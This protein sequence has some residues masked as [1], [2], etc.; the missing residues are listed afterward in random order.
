LSVTYQTLVYD[1]LVAGGT[2]GIAGGVARQNEQQVDPNTNQIIEV[3]RNITGYR[4][5][6]MLFAHYELDLLKKGRRRY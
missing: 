3:T 2:A 5:S 6:L 4:A 1:E